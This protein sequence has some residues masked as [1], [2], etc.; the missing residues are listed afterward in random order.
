MTPEQ[1]DKIFA[2]AANGP[3]PPTEPPDLVQRVQAAVLKDLR[4]VRPLPAPWVGGGWGPANT[5]HAGPPDPYNIYIWNC[6]SATNLCTLTAPPTE[7]RGALVCGGGAVNTPA[8]HS[9][10][11]SVFNWQGNT[12]SCIYNWGNACCWQAGAT[13]PDAKVLSK[14]FHLRD[15]VL[16]VDRMFQVG[17]AT[18]L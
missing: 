14:P 10:S 12:W 8:V 13:P 6:H 2:D 1:M 15:L 3:V 11:W 5:G 18:G 7:T 4:P 16:E 9:A 17:S